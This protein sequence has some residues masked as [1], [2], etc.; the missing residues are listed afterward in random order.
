MGRLVTLAADAER[1]FAANLPPSAWG[2]RAWALIHSVAEELPCPTCRD[3]GIEMFR[4]M[5][6]LVNHHKGKPLAFPESVCLLAK[7]TAEV[8]AK[9]G[10]CRVSLPARRGFE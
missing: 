6:D 9:A 5:H 4:A 7:Q 10:A 2:P 3:E 1:A 8:A